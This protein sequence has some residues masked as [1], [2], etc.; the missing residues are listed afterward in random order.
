M[1]NKI[2]YATIN[3]Q[4]NIVSL[5]PYKWWFDAAFEKKRKH[6]IIRVSV[7]FNKRTR[8]VTVVPHIYERL[9]K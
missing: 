6:D 4:G 2:M 7:T 9:P 8:H 3:S 1:K 5:H